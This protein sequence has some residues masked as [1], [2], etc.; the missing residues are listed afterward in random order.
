MTG[1]GDL[2]QHA[3]AD[4][5]AVAVV[6]ALEAVDVDREH[7]QRLQRGARAAHCAIGEAFD[8]AQV[9]YAGQCVDRSHAFP[10]AQARQLPDH[11]DRQH[12]EHDGEQSHRHLL[13]AA[14]LAQRLHFRV[15]EFLLGL[16]ALV[17]QLGAVG[18][19]LLAQHLR[20]LVGALMRH[21]FVHSQIALVF[22]QR[23]LRLSA[24]FQSLRLGFVQ[25]FRVALVAAGVECRAGAVELIQRFAALALAGQRTTAFVGD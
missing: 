17:F 18:V 2:L 14:G 16:Q 5:M 23:C 8:A 4:G 11:Q 1:A 21:F 6:D 25:L 24:G 13:P 9:R 22:L 15:L 3:I 19:E 10:D 20:L 12:A 7:R